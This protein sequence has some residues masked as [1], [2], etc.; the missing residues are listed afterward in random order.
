[1]RGSIRKRGDTYLVTVS[2]GVDPVTGKR[3]RIFRTCPTEDD[4]ERELTNVLRGLDTGTFADPGRLTLA[5]YLKDQWMPHITTRVRPRTALRYRQLLDLHV[6]PKIGAVKMAKLRPAHVQAVIDAMLAAG[7]APRTVAQGYRTLHAALKQAVRWQLIA[8][9]PADAISPPRAGRPTLHVPDTDTVAR[10]L[11]AA[12]GTRL[13]L[14]LALAATTGMRR[15][16]VLGLTWSGVDLD[17][18]LARVKTSLQQVDGELVFVAPK[19]D[20]AR[21]TI[22]LP[23]ATVAL[24]RSHRKEQARRRLL[25]GAAWADLD[26]VLEDGDGR[27]I[28]PDAVSRAFYRLARKIGRPG[29]RFHDLRH[30]YATTLLIAGVHPKIASEAL[31]HSSVGFTMDVYSHVLPTMQEVAGQAIEAAL[32]A[33]IGGQS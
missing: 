20:R 11:V 25:L 26:L 5:K 18:G 29:L 15:G 7:R 22:A 24:L 30:A 19:T 31:G 14:P 1:M 32:G 13:Y 16:E 4:A 9:N 3:S 12:Q 28:S 27:P 6:I 33:A 2:A 21:R 10:L 23:P 17:A 8:V